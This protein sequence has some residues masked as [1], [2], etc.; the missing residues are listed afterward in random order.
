M[1]LNRFFALLPLIC[2]RTSM[3]VLI[4]QK[5]R[6]WLTSTH[7]WTVTVVK[8]GLQEALGSWFVFARGQLCQAWNTNN[9]VKTCKLHMH[10]SNHCTSYHCNTQFIFIHTWRRHD[11][12]NL[13][14]MSG[15][16]IVLPAAHFNLV[17]TAWFWLSRS[18]LCCT[19]TNRK[20]HQLEDS[21]ISE[22]TVDTADM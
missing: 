1:Y 8:G 16:N 19:K 7:L 14:M 20:Q 22:T 4:E 9:Q 21:L 18:P 6:H 15:C 10:N 2:L 17:R 3:N 13:V 12:S 11:L 5:E